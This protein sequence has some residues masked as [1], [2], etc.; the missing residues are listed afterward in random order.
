VTATVLS[1]AGVA[2]DLVVDI[3]DFA[4]GAGDATLST[5]GLGSCV[6][7][8]LHDARTGV[9]GLAHFL[10]PEAT[11][12][13]TFTRPAKFATTGV[14]LLVAEMRLHGATGP[15]V[16]KLVGGA[17]MFGALLSGGVN[18]GQRNVEAVRTALDRLGIPVLAEE[19]GGE[20][21]RSLRVYAAS[22]RVQVRSLAGRDRD[23]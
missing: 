2:A 14:P 22:G 9:S 8:V 7:L 13:S 15:L 11:P 10:L 21:G 1:P 16:A 12:T 19:V 6:A 18:M 23:L 20:C 3:A 4:V 5:T 17:R